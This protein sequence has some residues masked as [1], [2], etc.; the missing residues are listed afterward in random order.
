MAFQVVNVLRKVRQKLVLIL[1]QLYECMSR[2]E[3]LA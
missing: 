2:R 3:F 1:Q